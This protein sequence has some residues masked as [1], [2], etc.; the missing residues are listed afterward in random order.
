MEVG[1][2]K[3]LLTYRL[4]IPLGIRK[5]V[6]EGSRF[7]IWTSSIIIVG[8]AIPGFLFAIFL[9][10]LF[11][12]GSFWDVFPLRGLTSDNW[13]ALP[14]YAK[15]LD[16]FWHLVLPIVSMALAAFAT[17]T[18]LRTRSFLDEVRNQYVL[19]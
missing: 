5:A 1:V 17:M 19:S 12:G 2:W 7:D 6:S 9:I 10:I 15:I 3:T 8:Y 18:L 4:S 14:W 13:A 16:Y 11:A